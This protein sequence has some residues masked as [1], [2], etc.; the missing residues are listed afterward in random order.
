MHFLCVFLRLRL[1]II[2]QDPFL[3]S[4]SVRENLDPTGCCTDQQ[5][6]DVL[7]RCHMIDVSTQQQMPTHHFRLNR[8]G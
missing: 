3:F 8:H 4:G 5:I 1:A 6:S 7:R 2:P